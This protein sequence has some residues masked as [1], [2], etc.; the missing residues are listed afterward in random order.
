MENVKVA[1]LIFT[2]DRVGELLYYEKKYI[3]RFKPVLN[4]TLVP[5]DKQTDICVNI[6]SSLKPVIEAEMERSGLTAQEVVNIALVTYFGLSPTRQKQS[7]VVPVN[8]QVP[9][10]ETVEDDYI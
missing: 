4:H 2:P 5:I 8:Q 1:Y 10:I 6:W 9:K 3:Q 7:E